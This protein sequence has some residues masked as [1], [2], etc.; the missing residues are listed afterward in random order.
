MAIVLLLLEF[1]TNNTAYLTG[2]F[3]LGIETKEN[4]ISPIYNLTHIKYKYSPNVFCGIDAQYMVQCRELV[5]PN[6]HHR[7]SHQILCITSRHR[8]ACM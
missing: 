8:C 6:R 2:V 7:P 1:K 4:K 5:T 3:R